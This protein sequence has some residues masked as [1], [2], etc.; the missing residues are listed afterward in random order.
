MPQP[1]TG[2][3]QPRIGTCPHGLPMG[4]CPICNGMGG[5]GSTKQ[6][7]NVRKS[8]EMTWSQCFAMGVMMKQSQARAEAQIEAQQQQLLA[9]ISKNITTYISNVRQSI[10]ILQN[11]L[12]PVLAKGIMALN[13]VIVT[14]LLTVL[15]QI[16]KLLNKI[17]SFIQDVRNMILQVVEKLA[18]LYGEMKN[19]INKKISDFLKKTTKKIFKLFSLETI[20][21]DDDE[22][23]TQKEDLETNTA[24]QE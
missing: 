22:I 8:G 14:P 1:I 19:F 23:N 18:N 10:Q 12:P 13:A 3:N 9:Q 7:N 15:E 20:D 16:P 24:K 5:G 17:Q 6:S 4:A 2:I 11:S 21:E